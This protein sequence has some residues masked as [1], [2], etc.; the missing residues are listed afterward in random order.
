MGERVS[1]LNV[2]RQSL[3]LDIGWVNYHWGR[4]PDY[5]LK[6]LAHL[7]KR[8][9]IPREL[10]RHTAKGLRS[11]AHRVIR[12]RFPR[13]DSRVLFFVDSINQWRAVKSIKEKTEDAIFWVDGKWEGEL[14][15]P[16]DLARLVSL[17]Y[18]PLILWEA[19]R[20]SPRF[21]PW[22][23]KYSLSG[24]L[25]A[26][27]YFLVG[28]LIM[29]RHKPKALVLANDFGPETRALLFAAKYL[30]IPTFYVQH[31]PVTSDFPPLEVDHALL[32]G[33]L[34]RDHY[35]VKNPDCKIHLVG[36]ARRAST[37]RRFDTPPLRTNRL[38]LACNDF[39]SRET[40]EFLL[41][42]LSREVPELKV[43]VR[44]HPSE[45]R[46]FSMYRSVAQKWNAEY[47][48]PVVESSWDYLERL[49]FLVAGNSGI[50][51]EAAFLGVISLQHEKLTSGW[52]HYGYQAAGIVRCIKTASEIRPLFDAWD[53]IRHQLSSALTQCDATFG[54]AHDGRSP[55]ISAG[56]ITRVARGEALPT[57]GGF[58][59]QPR[60]PY[61]SHGDL[62]GPSSH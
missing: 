37:A 28:A 8:P 19:L 36:M 3:R 24:Y 52:D 60:E 17:L 41:E 56:I 42:E 23:L 55:E 4:F 58:F 46:R 16:G 48:D 6:L 27:G 25:N 53:E 33:T 30:K 40:I 21:Q 1:L 45:W 11:T 34:A 20:K 62:P 29:R 7:F 47:S 14:F 12:K 54:T 18:L 43:V 9:G 15:F 38:G 13:Q 44:P 61:R 51:L 57:D 39:D 2:V 59:F 5:Y 49:D 35:A 50:S 10:I 32:D 26:Y 31:A 22:T